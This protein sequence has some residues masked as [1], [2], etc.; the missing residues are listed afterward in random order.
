MYSQDKR[1][2]IS[3]SSNVMD[4]NR[5][6]PNTDPIPDDDNLVG[7]PAIGAGFGCGLVLP[8]NA[9]NSITTAMDFSFKKRNHYFIA[10]AIF[11]RF[12]EEFLMNTITFS[13]CFDRRILKHGAISAGI[14]G[15]YIL[16]K[17]QNFS[18]INNVFYPFNFGPKLGLS[19]AL[20]A[21]WELSGSFEYGLY[22]FADYS[23]DPDWDQNIS[24]Y[25]KFNTFNLSLRYDLR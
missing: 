8:I 19:H 6:Y 18:Y 5:Y 7:S 17:N 16:D 2:F 4:L 1:F 21:R 22:K 15:E 13:S 3:M 24:N 12:D 11:S 23:R 14:F 9:K 20:S 25:L 10:G